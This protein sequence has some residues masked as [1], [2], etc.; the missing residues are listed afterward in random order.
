MSKGGAAADT[1]TVQI[2]TR[3][4]LVVVGCILSVMGRHA[5]FRFFPALAVL[6]FLI[7]V[8]GMV[9]LTIA[10]PLQNWTAQISEAVLQ[11]F[12]SADVSH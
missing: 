10:G 4:V 11:I 2:R 1:M 5:L 9:R 7:P 8:P 6:V 12:G 3:A